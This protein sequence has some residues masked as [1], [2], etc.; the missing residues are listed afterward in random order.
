MKIKALVLL[1]LI[2]GMVACATASPGSVEGRWLLDSG[3]HPDGAIPIDVGQ[4]PTLALDGDRISGQSHCN[5]FSGRFR[6]NSSGRFEIVDGL[7]V[8]EM[9]CI[10]EEAMNAEQRLYD[11]LS[12]VNSFRIEDGTLIL[13]GEGHR[14]AYSA[15]T[16]TPGS[17]SP[18][19]GDPAQPVTNLWFPPESFG[20]WGLERGALDGSAIPIAGT[21][22]VTLSISASGFGGQVC[23]QYGF[24]SPEVGDDSFPEI[25]STMMLCTEPVVMDSEAM[26]LDALRRFESARI[27]DGRLVIEGDGVELIFRATGGG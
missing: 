1:V 14:L 9:A 13:E 18:S 17:T 19:S 2:A 24:V 6:V 25:F 21:H 10:D 3:T 23:N 27:E 11:T 7:A 8:T 22:P 26:Y 16:S 20:D 4:R 5:T 15:D 12:S